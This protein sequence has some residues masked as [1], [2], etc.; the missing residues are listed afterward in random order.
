MMSKFT[1]GLKTSN[2]MEWETPLSLFNDLNDRFGPFTLDPCATPENAKCMVFYTKE[3]DGLKQNWEG[4]NVFM[5]PPYGN[6]VK[7]WIKKAFMES[8]K[9]DTQVICVVA[10]RTDTRWWH[11]Y[12][13]CADYVLFVKGRIKFLDPKRIKHEFNAPFPTAIVVF[14]GKRKHPVFESYI[15]PSKRR[16]TLEKFTLP[17]KPREVN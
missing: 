14:I 16:T 8:K 12:C 4:E 7:D 5:N 15:Q 13:M 3:E 2:S 11:D 6:A 10:S 1:N 9:K 17:P